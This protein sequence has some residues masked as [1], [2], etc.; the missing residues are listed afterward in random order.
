MACK[1]AISY[2]LVSFQKKED[3]GNKTCYTF[4]LSTK[5]AKQLFALHERVEF[6][7]HL[8]MNTALRGLVCAT[9]EGR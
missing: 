1:A 4:K 6:C 2:L 8:F 9:A 7:L 5:R 3:A